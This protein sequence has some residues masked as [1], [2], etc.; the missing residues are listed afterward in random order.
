MYTR[1]ERND[2]PIFTPDES[3]VQD[4]SSLTSEASQPM[5]QLTTKVG[6]HSEL[7]SAYSDTEDLTVANDIGNQTERHYESIN[8]PQRHPYVSKPNF[9]SRKL[10]S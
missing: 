4:D 7:A 1:R 8:N 2:L 5:I 10:N 9:N 6:C 3:N